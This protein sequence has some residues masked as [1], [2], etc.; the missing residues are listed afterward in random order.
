VFV[1]STQNSLD[2][3]DILKKAGFPDDLRNAVDDD[4]VHRMFTARAYRDVFT[5]S[6]KSMIYTITAK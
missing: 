3:A 5:Y 4:E 1:K 2:L 6:D